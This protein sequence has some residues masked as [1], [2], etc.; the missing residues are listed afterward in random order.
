ML[1]W[2]V[3]IVLFLVFYVVAA[4]EVE[5]YIAPIVAD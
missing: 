5:W 4:V 3:F 1:E 2:I